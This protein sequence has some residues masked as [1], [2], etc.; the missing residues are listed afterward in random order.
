MVYGDQRRD[1]KST[2]TRGLHLM[3]ELNMGNLGKYPL[4]ECRFEDVGKERVK[5]ILVLWLNRAKWRIPVKTW[6]KRRQ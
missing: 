6:Q 1:S 2:L 3:T 5:M 4:I